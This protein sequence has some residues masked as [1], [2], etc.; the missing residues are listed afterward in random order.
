MFG[1]RNAWSVLLVLVPLIWWHVIGFELQDMIRQ[2]CVPKNMHI[3]LV[4]DSERAW[5]LLMCPFGHSI[6]R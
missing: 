1:L 4:P 3:Y 6:V 2:L 5:P